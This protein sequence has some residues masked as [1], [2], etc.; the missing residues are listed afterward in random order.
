MH[1][2]EKLI[3]ERSSVCLCKGAVSKYSTGVSVQQ[4]GMVTYS[5]SENLPDSR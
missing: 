4:W 3:D 5:P 2:G 1:D